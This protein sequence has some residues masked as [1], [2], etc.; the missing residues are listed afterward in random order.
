[1]ADLK[2]V[3]FLNSAITF[4]KSLVDDSETLKC[5][6]YFSADKRSKQR[7][8]IVAEKLRRGRSIPLDRRQQSRATI[9]LG[10]S[11]CVDYPLVS[12]PMSSLVSLII[13]ISHPEFQL[14][15]LGRQGIS[16]LQSLG[17]LMALNGWTGAGSDRLRR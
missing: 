12:Q 4:K 3:G 9:R 15:G 5:C 11:G 8:M 2:S 13:Q 14:Q 17:K 6:Y 16:E 7:W 10:Q 1:M